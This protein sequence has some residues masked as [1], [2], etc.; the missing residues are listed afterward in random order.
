MNRGIYLREIQENLHETTGIEINPSS[1]CCFLQSVNFS[2]QKLKIVA[3]QR[4]EE[5]RAQFA[6]DVNIYDP[7]MLVF[8]VQTDEIA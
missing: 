7:E 4:D 3:K 2:R 6:C 1:I 5:L 8:L